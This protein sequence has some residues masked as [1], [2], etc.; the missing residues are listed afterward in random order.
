[1]RAQPAGARRDGCGRHRLLAL[2]ARG[3]APPLQAAL[4]LADEAGDRRLL[5][6]ALYNAGFAPLERFTDQ[7]ERY[8]E[9][10]PYFEK[11][12]AIYR[13]LEDR[14]G[15]AGAL[16]ALA[17]SLAAHGDRE[18]YLEMAGQSLELSRELG[19]PFRTGWG[20]HMVGLAHMGGG[21]LREAVEAFR[22]SLDMWVSAGDRSGI[23]LLLGD[24]S[25]LAR[26][27]GDE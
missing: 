2:G 7:A 13:E 12:L 14:A 21:R 11:S 3:H 8:R 19:D 10:R 20:A 26:L 1:M 6:E 5:A 23:L 9:G 25:T 27:R 17:G 15:E 16:W 24:I 22:E 18:G 4:A